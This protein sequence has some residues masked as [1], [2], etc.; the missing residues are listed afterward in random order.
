[1]EISALTLRGCKPQIQNGAGFGCA[2]VPQ[3]WCTK[4]FIVLL[5]AAEMSK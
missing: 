4:C 3:M 5:S 1:M 2:V